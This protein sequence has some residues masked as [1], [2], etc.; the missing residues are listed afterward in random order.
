M[1]VQF[2]AGGPVGGLSGNLLLKVDFLQQRTLS[3]QL[4]A[5]HCY[6]QA[7]FNRLSKDEYVEYRKGLLSAIRTELAAGGVEFPV[8]NY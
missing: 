4:S 6:V 3:L 8:K 5:F 2:Y 1:H 7:F